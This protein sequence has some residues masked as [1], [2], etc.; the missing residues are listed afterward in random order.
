[1]KEYNSKQSYLVNKLHSQKDYTQLKNK[2]KD[3]KR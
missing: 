1:M 2:M 3:K